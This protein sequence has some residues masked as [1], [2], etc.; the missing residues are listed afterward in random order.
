MR[1]LLLSLILLCLGLS[2]PIACAA[3]D[4]VTGRIVAVH[5]GDT[6]TLLTAD[7]RQLRIRL[8]EIDAPEKRQPY[9][10]KSKQEL[11]ALCFGKTA[12]AAYVD[13][14]RYG[15]MVAR[16]HVDGIDINAEMVR[17]G[18]AW[19]YRKYAKDPTFPALEAAA[20]DAKRGLWSLPESDRI[21]PWEW[22]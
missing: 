15:R 16:L 22:R 9:G 13:T 2:Q 6:V 7:K 17:R 19:V 8:S 4:E 18:A 3:T 12:V 1:V 20:R 11:S 21:P 14:D 10:T 5:D